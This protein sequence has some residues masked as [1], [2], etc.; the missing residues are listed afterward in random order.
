MCLGVSTLK[1]IV[2]GRKLSWRSEEDVKSCL[3]VGTFVPSSLKVHWAAGQLGR[4]TSED[5]Q[6]SR[7]TYSDTIKTV[8]LKD[9]LSSPARPSENINQIEEG[10]CM[11]CMDFV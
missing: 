9:G 10:F 8:M 5:E 3:S 11:N 2:C 7:V 1:L 4:F 6:E